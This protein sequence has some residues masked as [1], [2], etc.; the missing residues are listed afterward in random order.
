MSKFTPTH[1]H[2]AKGGLYM[3]TGAAILQCS[4]PLADNQ[5]LMVY[6]APDGRWF[7]RPRAEFYNRFETL[8]VVK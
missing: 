7:A 6:E 3:L 5:V 4:E 1:R 8:E 2:R